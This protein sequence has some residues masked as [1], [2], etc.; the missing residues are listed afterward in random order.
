VLVDGVDLAS[1][2]VDDVRRVIAVVPQEPT[3]F[4]WT[5]KQNVGQEFTDAEVLEVLDWCGLDP[6]QL[7]GQN[8]LRAALNAGVNQGITV[9]QQQLLMAA[10]ALV[11]RPKII[12]LD[13]CTAALDRESAD[14]LL[15][16]VTSHTEDATVLSIAHRLRFVLKSDRILVLGHLGTV[17]GL[18]TPAKLLE[19]A[20]GY[21][22]TNLRLEQS[23][24]ADALAATALAAAAAKAAAPDE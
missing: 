19:D 2:Q 20:D 1:L 12:I 24:E 14:R 18:D 5:L 9:G 4:P 7:T 23:E 10:R 8:D 13:E 21:F 3:F 6:R 15:E 11:R 16:V 22:A 17:L